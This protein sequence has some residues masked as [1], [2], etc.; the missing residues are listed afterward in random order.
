MGDVE[1]GDVVL[2]HMQTCKWHHIEAPMTSDLMRVC[3][4]LGQARALVI[5]DGRMDLSMRM[6]LNLLE[7]DIIVACKDD[8]IVG[9]LLAN[10]S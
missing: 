2:A 8:R 9:R 4:S 5:E 6:S 1:F 3:E 7:Q 10:I